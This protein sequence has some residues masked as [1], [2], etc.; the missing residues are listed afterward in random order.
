[1]NAWMVG[2]RLTTTKPY[3][4]YAQEYNE[5]GEKRTIPPMC[6]V[7]CGKCKGCLRE[8]KRIWTH[9]LVAE[10]RCHEQNAFLTLTYAPEH[11]PVDAKINKRDIQLFLK[12]LRN[13]YGNLRYFIT[14][15]Y[16]EQFGRPHYHALI[17]GHDFLGGAERMRNHEFNNRILDAIWRCG[18][19]TIGTVTEASCAYVAGYVQK[20]MEDEE[21]FTMMSKKPP[22]GK[23]YILRPENIDN[24]RRH[25]ALTD[26][27]GIKTSIP[28]I[29][30]QWIKEELP[31][32]RWWIHELKTEVREH[33]TDRQL[34]SKEIF[35]IAE[36]KKR[37]G[38]KL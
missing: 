19:V 37:A 1:M 24:M 10:S 28:P 21:T 35:Y 17:F 32:E 14:G 11:L 22:I 29:Y 3:G 25:R 5:F 23:D 2:G 13:N 15:E 20:K 36:D 33:K 38:G 30:R 9:R 34:N 16:G 8:K 7:P 18:E 31:E 26:K 4:P 12:R 27:T 6:R